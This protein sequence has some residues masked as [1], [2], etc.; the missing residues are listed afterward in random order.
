MTNENR[1]AEFC[2]LQKKSIAVDQ[3]DRYLHAQSL[4]TQEKNIS[5]AK[6]FNL[7][8]I[9]CR[10]SRRNAHLSSIVPLKVTH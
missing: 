1:N 3:T 8:I 10:F 9:C 4:V 7:Y 2:N 5:G 6:I